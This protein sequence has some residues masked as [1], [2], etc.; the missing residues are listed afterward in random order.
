MA[1]QVPVGKCCH[2]RS[3]AANHVPEA[4]SKKEDPNH[5]VSVAP[6]VCTSDSRRL[7][8]AKLLHGLIRSG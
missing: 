1:I 2:E 4:D 8:A 5:K 3:Q 6:R 7:P